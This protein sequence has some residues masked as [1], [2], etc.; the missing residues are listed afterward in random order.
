MAY[1]SLFFKPGNTTLCG[2]HVK[3]QNAF[4]FSVF[5]S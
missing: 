3:I 2:A 1:P 5:S 4:R